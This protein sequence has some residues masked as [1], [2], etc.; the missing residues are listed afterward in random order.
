MQRQLG[1]LFPMSGDL[2]LRIECVKT[3]EQLSRLGHA[4]GRWVE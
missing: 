4:P 2:S 1:H 3:G